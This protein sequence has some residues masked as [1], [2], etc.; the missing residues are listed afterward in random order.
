[1]KTCSNI[2]R[3]HIQGRFESNLEDFYAICDQ[4]ELHLKSAV[5]CINQTTSSNRYMPVPPHPSRL[6]TT[7][8]QQ[9]DFLPYNA[10][11]ATSKQQVKFANEIKQLLVQAA[12]DGK[13]E[14]A[15]LQA[16]QQSQQ[17]QPQQQQQQ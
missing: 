11:V 4:I 9:T 15:Q 14:Q 5:D 12:A 7:G 6:D 10:Y 1:M 16:Q 8:G 2:T 13:G 17:Q 3:S